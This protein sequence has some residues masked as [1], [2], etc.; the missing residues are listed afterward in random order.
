MPIYTKEQ[1]ENIVK[2]SFSQREVLRK[3]GLKENGGYYNLRKRIKECDIRHF[4]GKGWLKGKTYYKKT[5]DEMFCLNGSINS[6]AI[7]QSLFVRGLKKK[8]CEVCN[9]SL[10]LNKAIPLELNHKNGNDRDNRLENLEIICPNCHYFT[11]NYKSKNRRDFK[12]RL[13]Q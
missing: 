2:D 10:W 4:T 7:K 13:V 3:L 12:T 8:I 1:I 9:L 11:D 5:N 6:H